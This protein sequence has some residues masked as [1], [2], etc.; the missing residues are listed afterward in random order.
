[1]QDELGRVQLRLKDGL[2]V[3]HLL[4]RGRLRHASLTDDVATRVGDGV[5]HDGAS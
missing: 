2:H 3:N 5:R 1:M 4:V